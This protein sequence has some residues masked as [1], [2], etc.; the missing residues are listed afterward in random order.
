MM[1]RRKL[2]VLAIP[3]VAMAGCT[4][5]QIAQFQQEWSNFVDKVNALLAKGCGLLPGFIATANSIEAI[6]AVFYPSG[7]M[8]IAAGAAGVQAVA[9][10]ICGM[11]PAGPPPVVAARL[12]AAR[13]SGIPTIAGNVVINGRVI[14]ISGYGVR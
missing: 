6:A 10:A 5:T 13:L 4:S 2:L 9:S 11:I 14:P 8:A 1:N 3:A 7:A 12:H